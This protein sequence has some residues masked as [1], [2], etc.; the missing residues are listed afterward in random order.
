[1]N[2]FLASLAGSASAS[3]A[4]GDG[5]AITVAAISTPGDGQEPTSTDEFA[6]L[7][8]AYLQTQ[9]VTAS[10]ADADANSTDGN[11]QDSQSVA[12]LGDG[13]TVANF[14]SS[15]ATDGVADIATDSADG[16]AVNASELSFQFATTSDNDGSAGQSSVQVS[17]AT[18]AVTGVE[19]AAA[20]VAD[21]AA[22]T[23]G[24]D[25]LNAAAEGAAADALTD[26][27][28]AT[29]GET[30]NSPAASAGGKTLGSG[31][32]NDAATAATAATTVT[33]TA[34]VP[35]V[36]PEN[37]ADATTD[38]QVSQPESHSEEPGPIQADHSAFEDSAFDDSAETFDSATGDDADGQSRLSETDLLSAR[39]A[40]TYTLDDNNDPTGDVTTPDDV[41][42]VGPVGGGIE[43]AAAR[44]TPH[45]TAAAQ[46]YAP[47]PVADQ[48]AEAIA[49]R[50][51]QLDDAGN[52]SFEVQ[53][54]PP[55]LGR[56]DIR[57]ERV[58]DRL[59]AH[60]TIAD[61][62]ARQ[63]IQQQ[64]PKLHETLREQGIQLHQFDV[65]HQQSSPQQ[66]QHSDQRHE[67][68][69]HTS[70]SDSP[71]PTSHN[72]ATVRV[73]NGRLDIRA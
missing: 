25:D 42:V 5:A 11:G 61:E 9:T 21:P 22:V 29:L 8:A 16:G 48:V 60:V 23:I 2:A 67:Q 7:V 19:S 71:A 44:Q 1:M 51:E 49:N 39:I 33:S 17:A 20:T 32:A 43:A 47:P 13:G 37:H 50:I 68:R 59:V 24:S 41:S 10:G 36:N 6:A 58:N 66:Q 14:L 4:T 56:V 53:L 28:A 34:T 35:A 52:L 70:W 26:G 12:T 54:D 72:T 57:I 15:F 30:A 63:M 3:S 38:D 46:A 73:A 27:Q 69:P 64:M 55:E 31:T 18:Q 65:S 40:A 45:A 62:A